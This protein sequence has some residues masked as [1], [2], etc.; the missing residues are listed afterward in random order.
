[1]Q[2]MIV[3]HLGWRWWELGLK[4]RAIPVHLQSDWRVSGRLGVGKDE[5][6]LLK[7]SFSGWRFFSHVQYY[8]ACIGYG[9][10]ADWLA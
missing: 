3:K 6:Q 5:T 8:P 1:M 2:E 4:K 10:Q 7:T 9:I